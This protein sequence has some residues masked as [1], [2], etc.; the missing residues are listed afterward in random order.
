MTEARSG[1]GAYRETTPAKRSE[2]DLSPR[3]PELKSG[4]VLNTR[5]LCLL[6]MFLV[7]VNLFL[8]D[9]RTDLTFLMVSVARKLMVDNFN[10]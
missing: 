7:S 6:Y 8:H 10:P 3:P 5:Q 9:P 4:F 1:T 2:R